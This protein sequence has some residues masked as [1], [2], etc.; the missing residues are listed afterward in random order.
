MGDI[1]DFNKF[2]IWAAV[3]AAAIYLFLA[4]NGN[5]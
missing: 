2:R 5:A 1:K 3:A 4:A